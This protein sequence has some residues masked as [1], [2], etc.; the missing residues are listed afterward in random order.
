MGYEIHITRAENWSDPDEA[1]A[2]TAEEWL[3]YVKRDPELKLAATMVL[4]SPSGQASRD[5]PTLG[6]T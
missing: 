4:V 6:S 1:R 2:I 3:E 5:T